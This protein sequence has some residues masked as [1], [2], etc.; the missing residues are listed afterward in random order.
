MPVWAHGGQPVDPFCGRRE[1]LAKLQR[2]AADPEVRLIGVS[3]W[4][5][6][7]KTALVTQW[8]TAH[9]GAR[10]RRGLFAWSFYEEPSADIWAEEL[11]SWGQETFR[12]RGRGGG[13]PS[14]WWPW[15]WACRWCWCS[16]GWRWPRRVRPA[17][18]GRLLDGVLR[19]ALSGLC[20]SGGQSLAVLT[21]RFPFADLERFD[22]A[23][24]RMLEV[25]P[26]TP[27]KGAD[28]LAGVG[29]GWLSPTERQD[30]SRE[31]DGHALALDAMARCSPPGC[32]RPTS[33]LCVLS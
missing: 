16:P 19:D 1:E 26:L 4:G 13:R 30:L 3:A 33:R 17:D 24:A 15:P 32:R 18:F 12:L 22:G 6:A 14:G 10:P 7:G 9:G 25:P 23:Q 8:L 28:L 11:L 20:R 29:V 21:S 2:W 31:V 27:A 5:G